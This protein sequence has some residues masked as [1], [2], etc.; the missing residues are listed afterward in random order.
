MERFWIATGVLAG[1]TGLSFAL[2]SV[3]KANRV[4]DDTAIYQNMSEIR[5]QKQADLDFDGDIA[6]LS[7]IEERYH[8][9]LPSL[10]ESP[11]ARASIHRIAKRKHK[12]VHR[13]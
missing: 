7:A 12:R 6:R 9:E 2:A 8:E 13:N 10:S 3:P 1:L 4:T 11:R 5:V